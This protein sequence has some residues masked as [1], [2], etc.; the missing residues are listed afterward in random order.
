[1]ARVAKL[2]RVHWH[3]VLALLALILARPSLRATVVGG[4]VVAAG[5]MLRAWAAGF[6]EKGGGL[7][8]D[9]PYRYLRHPLYL[10]SFVSAVGFCAMANVVWGWVMVLPLFAIL[11]GVQVS[12][13]ERFLRARYSEEYARYAARVPMVIPRFAGGAGESRAWRLERALLNREHWHVLMALALAG[14][15]FIK[16]RWGQ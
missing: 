14:L 5:L 6:L 4:A 16:W 11:Y 12:L 1:M 2:R 13:E 3:L 15:F 7:C 8:R 9:G 10:G